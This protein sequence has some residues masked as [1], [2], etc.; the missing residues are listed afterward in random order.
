MLHQIACRGTEPEFTIYLRVPLETALSRRNARSQDRLEA[1]SKE[2]HQIVFQT[3]E[4]LAAAFPDRIV[5]VD[6]QAAP[7]LIHE[8]I[9]SQLKQRW[10]ERS[11]A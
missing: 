7:E 3:Y 10:Q 6:G 9:W 8:Q 1:E 11:S 2:F 4:S 5:C